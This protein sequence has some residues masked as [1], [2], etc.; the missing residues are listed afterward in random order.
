VKKLPTRGKTEAKLQ[1]LSLVSKLEHQYLQPIAQPTQVLFQMHSQQSHNL[2]LFSS[3]PSSSL[4]SS[5]GTS[6]GFE[7]YEMST[8]YNYNYNNN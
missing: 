2:M 5:S 6:Q 1:I 8:A 4:T 7:P 3:S